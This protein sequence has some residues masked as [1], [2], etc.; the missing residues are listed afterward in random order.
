L[1]GALFEIGNAGLTSLA[2]GLSVSG[3]KYYNHCAVAEMRLPP[4]GCYWYGLHTP[5]LPAT[6]W[7]LPLAD[8]KHGVGAYFFSLGQR[9]K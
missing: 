9:Y 3:N 2:H 7:F 4:P 6:D 5:G 8:L 1:L